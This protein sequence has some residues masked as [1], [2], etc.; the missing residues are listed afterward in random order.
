MSW[1]VKPLGDVCEIV[2]GGTP[3]KRDNSLYG[4][5]ILWVTVGDMQA[6]TLSDTALKIT[7]AGVKE[8]ATNIIPAGN[9]VIATRVGLGKVCIIEHD[10][11]INQ[12]LK[13]IL[14]KQG[15]KIAARY[16]FW[17]FKLI[18]DEIK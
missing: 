13:G 5:N 17:W 2:G 3:S 6:D 11:A 1:E 4:G 16:L 9:V 18:G 14:P 7:P 15:V 12:D 10:A 8:S